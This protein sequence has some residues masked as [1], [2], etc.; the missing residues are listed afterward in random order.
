MTLIYKGGKNEKMAEF[1]PLQGYPITIKF[2]SY[3]LLAKILKPLVLDSIIAT[4][5]SILSSCFFAIFT[6]GSKFCNDVFAS[7]E[8]NFFS[9]GGLLLEERICF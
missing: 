2:T 5:L 3:P 6:K 9:K 1:L 7:M 8:G 4:K